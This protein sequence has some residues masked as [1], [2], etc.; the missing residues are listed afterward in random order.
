VRAVISSACGVSEERIKA[1]FTALG[2][3]AR[4]VANPYMAIRRTLGSDLA[5]NKLIQHSEFN[6]IRTDLELVN[7]TVLKNFPQEDFELLGLTYTSRD[8]A[9]GRLKNKNRRLA[10]IY[11]RLESVITEEFVKYVEQQS[12]QVPLLTVHDA[13]YYSQPIPNSAY[14]GV[15][16]L[17][18]NQ[19]SFSLVKFAH[20]ALWPTG[21][22]GYYENL[23]Q[24]QDSE[25]AQ[26]RAHIQAETAASRGYRS[27][28]LELDSGQTQPAAQWEAGISLS[29]TAD[30]GEY[31]YEYEYEYRAEEIPSH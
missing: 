16:D 30:V 23:I 27:E 2:F 29:Q 26:H 3:G 1:V 9:S 21:T 20:D 5:Y 19:H 14:L 11:Q 17:I 18:R 13:V 10:W 8:P 4:P 7:S 28:F 12:G 31:E 24:Q 25:A 15:H 6:Y 22:D